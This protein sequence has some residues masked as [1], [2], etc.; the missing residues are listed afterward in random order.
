MGGF[1]SKAFGGGVVVDVIVWTSIAIGVAAWLWWMIGRYKTKASMR[2]QVQT[3]R[4][5]MAAEEMHRNS[6][7]KG[8]KKEE[9]KA[10]QAKKVERAK[11]EYEDAR[12]NYHAADKEQTR[13]KNAIWHFQE[14][15]GFE[16]NLTGPGGITEEEL[17]Q[18]KQK[19]SDI[20]KIMDEREKTWHE[21]MTSHRI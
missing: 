2:R 17:S 16:E 5:Q 7:V 1:P 12:D 15:N 19:I 14:Q 20:K 18:Q 4:K 6:V 13:N 21:A 11:R 9:E 8:E 10:Q 3:R